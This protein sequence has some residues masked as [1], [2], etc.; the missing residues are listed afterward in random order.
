MSGAA[1]VGTYNQFKSRQSHVDQL[2]AGI[3]RKSIGPQTTCYTI[4]S[5]P[6]G[7]LPKFGNG[8]L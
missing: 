1:I 8:A 2:V 6:C 4:G 3:H 7:K 5:Q